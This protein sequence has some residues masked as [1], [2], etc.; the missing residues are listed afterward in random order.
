MDVVVLGDLAHVVV[1]DPSLWILRVGNL[2]ESRPHGF[3]L[4]WFGGLP[5][6]AED[7]HRYVARIAIDNDEPKGF[8][9]FRIPVGRW[10]Q[11]AEL[12]GHAV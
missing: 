4:V 12:A 10:G 8:V 11:F 2:C 9:N 1:A 7:R 3:A 5:M 6:I